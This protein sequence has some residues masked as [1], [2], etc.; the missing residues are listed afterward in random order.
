[1]DSSTHEA[2]QDRDVVFVVGQLSA[3][4]IAQ[5]RDRLGLETIVS[6]FA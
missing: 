3:F 4:S 1:M 5:L 2:R 6:T